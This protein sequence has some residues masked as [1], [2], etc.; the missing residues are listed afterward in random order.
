MKK[1]ILKTATLSALLLSSISACTEEETV[2][3]TFYNRTAKKFYLV[4]EKEMKLCEENA[5]PESNY[6]K[7]VPA[8]LNHKYNSDDVSRYEFIKRKFISEYFKSIPRSE[9]P[10]VEFNHDCDEMELPAREFHLSKIGD[11]CFA[12]LA[13][14]HYEDNK[15]YYKYLALPASTNK[16][17]ILYSAETDESQVG[18]VQFSHDVDGSIEDSIRFREESDPE[19]HNEKKYFLNFKKYLENLKAK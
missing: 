12:L 2:K 3:V 15:I 4:N 5:L 10:F 6:G 19:F 8:I 17:L 7:W 9:Q 14:K 18:I 13:F 1:L 16:V 11:F